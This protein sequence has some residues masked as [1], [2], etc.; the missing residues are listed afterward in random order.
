MSFFCQ[1]KGGTKCLLCR[2]VAWIKSD[3]VLIFPSPEEISPNSHYFIV[4]C[5]LLFDELVVGG[6]IVEEK[7]A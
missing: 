6:H 5:C 3:S 7:R 4:V 1:V 2:A